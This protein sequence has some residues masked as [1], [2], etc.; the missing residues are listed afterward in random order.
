MQFMLRGDGLH[1]YHFAN[2]LSASGGPGYYLVRTKQTI[3]GV[4]LVAS[5]DHKD[6]DR[7]RGA[8]AEDTGMTSVFLGPR[9]VASIGKISAEVGADFPVSIDNTALQVVA[10]YR[11]RAGFSI[12]F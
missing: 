12:R 4:Q 1:Q 11:L 7:F 8:A 9:V 10:D 2:D 3:I 6:V 5:A